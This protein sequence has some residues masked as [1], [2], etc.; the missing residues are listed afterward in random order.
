MRH[1][2]Q[3]HDKLS[4]KATVTY[5]SCDHPVS[6]WKI[7]DHYERRNNGRVPVF[8]I[9]GAE[10]EITTYKHRLS[11]DNLYRGWGRLRYSMVFYPGKS[12]F[13]RSAKRHRP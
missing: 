5:D 6:L 2:D 7:G 11:F 10:G 13:G 9:S 1:I 12:W 8:R 3:I 4:D